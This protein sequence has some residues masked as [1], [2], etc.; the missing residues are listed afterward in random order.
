VERLAAVVSLF[1]ADGMLV[2]SGRAPVD[3]LQLG[4]GDDTPF[5]VSVQARP[6]AVRYRVSF[7]T[8]AGVL[9]HVDRRV[10]L[11]RAVAAD[12]RHTAR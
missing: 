10:E 11:S 12:A 7:R 9:P 3:F 6:G 5:V 1:D 2:S 8:D 4:P